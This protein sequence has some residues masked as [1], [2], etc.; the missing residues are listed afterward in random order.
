V[1]D[2]APPAHVIRSASSSPT[3]PP[4]PYPQVVNFTRVTLSFLKNLLEGIDE[5]L[6]AAA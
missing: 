6:T 3:S 4:H 1:P 2:A 5:G